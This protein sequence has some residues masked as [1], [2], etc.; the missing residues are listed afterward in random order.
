ML[1]F[2]LNFFNREFFNDFNLKF[3]DFCKKKNDFL[4]KSY[5]MSRS[6]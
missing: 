1:F 3:N 5:N 4:L 6:V 2:C